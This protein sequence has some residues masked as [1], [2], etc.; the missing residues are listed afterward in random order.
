M[1]CRVRIET[2]LLQLFLRQENLEWIFIIP[3]IIFE[4]NI[5]AEQK[6]AQPNGS[7]FLFFI[8]FHCPKRFT[9]VCPSA[10]PASL[11]TDIGSLRR[12]GCFA[13]LDATSSFN[14]SKTSGVMR[15]AVKKYFVMWTRMS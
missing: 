11:P 2:T 4:I 7:D 10:T 12:I 1:V 8:S 13:I 14:L 5:N 15:K 3:V 6:Q 9:A